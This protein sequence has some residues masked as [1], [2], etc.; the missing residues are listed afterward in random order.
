MATMYDPPHLGEI[1]LQARRLQDSGE[2]R[3][4]ADRTV[5]RLSTSRVALSRALNGRANVSA[6]W[7]RRWNGLAGATQNT[8]CGCTP[9]Y[10]V[11]HQQL[12][13]AELHRA[14]A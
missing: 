9:L 6:G 11:A 7:R 14:S 3:G 1:G 12:T 2:Y 4:D 13:Q 10:D 8:G 5:D